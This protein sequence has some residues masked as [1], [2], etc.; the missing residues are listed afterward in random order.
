M[1]SIKKIQKEKSLQN[2]L[3]TSSV[4]SKTIILRTTFIL[5]VGRN[6]II[7]YSIYNKKYEPSSHS[8]KYLAC[9]KM[10][11]ACAFIQ[12]PPYNQLSEPLHAL[13][14]TSLWIL[15]MLSH[16]IMCLTYL[17]IENRMGINEKLHPIK[18]MGIEA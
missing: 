17:S 1:V 5:C 14:I 11:P 12:I 15:G 9:K 6:F 10:G 16:N 3:N 8:I 4:S 7:H 18:S 13:T 2:F